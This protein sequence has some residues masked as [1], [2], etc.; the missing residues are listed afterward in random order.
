[1]FIRFGC[2]AL[3][4]RTQ[5]FL[6][7]LL[8]FISWLPVNASESVFLLSDAND[9]ESAAAQVERQDWVELDNRIPIEG[10]VTWV[11]LD[12]SQSSFRI[13][14]LGT[15][16]ITDYKLYSLNT[17]EELYHGGLY[18]SKESRVIF[19]PE[20]LLPLSSAWGDQ[21]LLRVE[22]RIGFGVPI[23][24]LTTNQVSRLTATR[25]MGDGMYY[26]AICL[27]IIFSLFVGLFNRDYHAGRLAVTMLM[28]LFS[29]VTISGYGNLLIWPNQPQLIVTVLPAV[30][31][32]AGISS[33]WFSW[34]FLRDAASGTVFLKG[35]GFF[36]WV[37]TLSLVVVIT[38]D[39]FDSLVRYY[40]LA[41]SLL[42]ICTAI[43][44]AQR[45]DKASKY[46]IIS[47]VFIAA[48]I[49]LIPTAPEVQNYLSVPGTFSL[50]CIVISVMSRLAERIQKQ[51]IAAQVVASRAQFL[52]AMSHEL[53]TPLNGVIGFSELCASEP[54]TGQAA[55]YVAQI[56]RSSKLLLSVVNE[57][58][59]YSKLEADAVSTERAAMHLV[60]TLEN[61]TNT[62]SPAA[63][64]NDVSVE[65]SI[66]DDVAP[67]VMTD[68]NRCAQIL[69]N[70][71]S[72]AIKF[73]QG[74]H[75][76]LSVFKELGHLKFEVRDDGIGISKAALDTVFDP[77]KQASEQ[78]SRVFGGTG[79]GL[80]IAKQFAALIDGSINATSEVGV[81]SVFTLQIPY[82]EAKAES[83]AAQ[84]FVEFDFK[85]LSVLLVEDNPV[86][87]LLASTILGK[88][89]VAVDQVTNGKD[90]IER[91]NSNHYD[92][93]LMDIQMPELNGIEAT[94]LLRQGGCKTPII[95]LT[96]SNSEPDKLACEEVGMS[97]FLAKP[98]LKKE[99][100]AKVGQW[101]QPLSS[102]QSH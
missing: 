84:D 65:I 32:L 96:A 29:V 88:E 87:Q 97:D 61:I 23:D 71:I 54:L 51:E 14:Y 85:G 62:L 35:I 28:W 68:P 91:A 95:A 15:P 101:G 90:A 73:T 38:T 36:F 57:V 102:A 40:V 1:M 83:S 56:Q 18:A 64:S 77:Y 34:H 44:S 45:G 80:S 75:V 74:G 13:L 5:F 50:F 99:L 42:I 20:Y 16:Y 82:E 92:L 86:N 11:Y 22:S 17:G 66:A 70:L 39:F 72:N 27:M 4:F 76:K 58:L 79:L 26:G 10:S 8:L 30:I 33:S 69:M 52:A 93:I 63:N 31:C 94:A 7:S 21:L 9:W 6:C 55:S 98:F 37:N 41:M 3:T 12:L 48:P 19:H 49:L 67:A 47:L 46:L 43:V 89:G 53:R 24:F 100:L 60:E 2:F 25:F 78:T 59:D 81:G